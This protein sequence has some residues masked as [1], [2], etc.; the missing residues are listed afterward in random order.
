MHQN[1]TREFIVS[2]CIITLASFPYLT[3][4]PNLEDKM[5]TEKGERWGVKGNIFRLDS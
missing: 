2:S 5:S 1:D 3:D 4:T